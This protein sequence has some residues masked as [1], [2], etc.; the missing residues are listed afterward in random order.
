[1]SFI[2]L[3]VL[4]LDYQINFRGKLKQL[5][6]IYKSWHSGNLFKVSHQLME[7]SGLYGH[8]WAKAKSHPMGTRAIPRLGRQCVLH[9]NM[10][11]IN[12]FSSP[13]SPSLTSRGHRQLYRDCSHSN[14]TD[15]VTFVLALV[16]QSHPGHPQGACGED[17]VPPVAWQRPPWSDKKCDLLIVCEISLPITASIRVTV[18]NLTSFPTWHQPPWNTILVLLSKERDRC[19]SSH[20]QDCDWVL[21]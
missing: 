18:K 13:Y 9:L 3:V 5:L 8:S 12:P 6:P 11:F 2:P 14:G 20:T 15:G 21:I 19:C 17:T 10:N 4:F 7:L 16:M 1:M